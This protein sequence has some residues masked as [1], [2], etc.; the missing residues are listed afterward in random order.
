M[1]DNVESGVL[2]EYEKLKNLFQ[3]YTQINNTISILHN[4]QQISMSPG[5]APDRAEQMGALSKI[6][7]RLINAPEIKDLLEK[8]EAAPSES[9]SKEDQRNI[10]LMRKIVA[11]QNISEDLSTAI[12][13]ICNEGW[14]KHTKLRDAGDWSQMKDWIQHSVD[15]MREVGRD[16]K[17]RLG[18][19][20]A[21]EAL[22]DTFNTGM[23][24]GHVA[25]ELGKMEKSLPGL[26]REAAQ[27]Q[28]E[29]KPPVAFSGTFPKEQQEEL[30][31]RVLEAMG[32]DFNRGR[33]DFISGHPS[34]GG[35]SDD[36]R[37]TTFYDEK[38]FFKALIA[39]IHEGGHGIYNQ[40]LPREWR[41]QPAGEP[42]GMDLHE[43]QSRIMEVQAAMTPE[44]FE[45][46]E[47]QARDIFNRPDDPALSAENMR[48]LRQTVAPS[49]IRV[50][51]DEITYSA[52]I[53]L[54]HKLESALIEGTLTAEDLPQAWNDGMKNLLGITPP[55]HSQG[56][57][58]DVHWPSGAIGYFP[59]YTLGDMGA[60]QFFAAACKDRPEIRSELK[61][62]N[63]K[64]LQEWLEENVHSKGSLLTTEEIFVQATG[65]KL[66]ADDYL[67]H[68]SERYLGKPYTAPVSAPILPQQKTPEI[69]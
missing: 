48:K 38:N 4:D 29:E 24:A 42:L 46:L 64:P 10:K 36:T 63:F 21:Y 3:D 66:G 40:T 28:K 26:I 19:A 41:Y 14:E 13:N 49:F 60:A 1:A 53:I 59:A 27:K 43:S 23:K 55:D 54:R 9:F 20:S 68:L 18:F 61:T 32:F 67:N 44:F 37:L 11:E 2:K 45:Y 35:T 58:Q 50:Y 12:S 33:L 30:C 8:V 25:Q 34:S 57:M 16:K 15:T 17:E 65:K 47:I 69:N 7:H 56:C 31:R 39:A 5:S 22:L 62:G 6:A 52:H 51:A